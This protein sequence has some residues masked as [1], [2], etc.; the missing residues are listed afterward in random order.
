MRVSYMY[1]RGHIKWQVNKMKHIPG[2]E[3][4]YILGGGYRPDS[5][6]ENR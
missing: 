5:N 4:S 3:N 6:R 1:D 2:E